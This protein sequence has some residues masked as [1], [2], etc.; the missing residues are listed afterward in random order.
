M[1][2]YPTA[3]FYILA[4]DGG[5]PLLYLVFNDLLFELEK[6]YVVVN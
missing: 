6:I 5:L 2:E 3:I 4:C 1:Q